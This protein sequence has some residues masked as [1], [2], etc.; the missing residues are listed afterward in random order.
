M[1]RLVKRTS[2][3]KIVMLNVPWLSFPLLWRI[4]TPKILISHNQIWSFSWI[5]VCYSSAQ[6]S[7]L[8]RFSKN[9]TTTTLRFH[10]AISKKKKKSKQNKN[11]N[12][13]KQHKF[14]WKRSFGISILCLQFYP[15][16]STSIIHLY[17]LHISTFCLSFKNTF[18]STIPF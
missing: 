13:V 5:E 10:S 1:V 7:N 6:Y 17:F 11:K 18:V 16:N 3:I 2:F 8:T 4:N 12:K 15:I 9:K 14:W